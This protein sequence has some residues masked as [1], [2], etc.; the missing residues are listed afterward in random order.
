MRYLSHTVLVGLEG[1]DTSAAVEV[2]EA[3]VG[4]RRV[5]ARV[6]GRIL[7]HPAPFL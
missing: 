2:P 4:H 5:L 6:L 7:E 1:Q 3:R